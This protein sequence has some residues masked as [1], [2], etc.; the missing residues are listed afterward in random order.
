M[1][2]CLIPT[3]YENSAINQNNSPTVSKKALRFFI[4]ISVQNQWKIKIADIKLAF[5]HGK[6]LTRNVNIQ[7]PKEA[8]VTNGHM[9]IETLLVQIN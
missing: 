5:L 4:V 1:H 9:E 2:A 8:V 3:G 6:Q 7:P